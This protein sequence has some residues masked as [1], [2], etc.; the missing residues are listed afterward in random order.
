MLGHHHGA[1]GVFKGLVRLAGGH[2]VKFIHQLHRC[3][4]EVRLVHAP[5]QHRGVDHHFGE[6]GAG[7]DLFAVFADIHL[8]GALVVVTADLPGDEG[9]L[10]AAG[11]LQGDRQLRG[12]HQVLLGQV[13]L[14]RQ[15]QRAVIAVIE[16]DLIDELQLVGA[17]Q[18]RV[19][20]VDALDPEGGH[21]HLNI[22]LAVGPDC[23]GF[24]LAGN[25]GIHTVFA[26]FI[27]AAAVGQAALIGGAVRL[28]QVKHHMGRLAQADVINRVK[29]HLGAVLLAGG[30]S[31]LGKSTHIGLSLVNRL[32]LHV[33]DDAVFLV[34]GQRAVVIGRYGQLVAVAIGVGQLCFGFWGSLENIQLVLQRLHLDIDR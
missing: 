21:I 22:E 11:I 18:L 6:V 10:L 5:P 2:R 14:L 8:V 23:H 7:A 12:L 29:P 34:K 31:A 13:A 1:E 9:L 26:V 19:G 15:Q 30:Q 20:L 27:H 33:A 16:D 28:F 32:E 3:R 24:A 25:F 4:R 17:A